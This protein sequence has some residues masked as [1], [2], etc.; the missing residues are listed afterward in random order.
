VRQATGPVDQR[1]QV[2][3]L[4]LDGVGQGVA[5]VA[6]AATVVIE[7]REVLP[8]AHAVGRISARSHVAPQTAI[9]AGPCPN[10]A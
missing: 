8:S 4:P 9:S 5:A 10:V 7:R 1:S 2:L 3:E 6:A